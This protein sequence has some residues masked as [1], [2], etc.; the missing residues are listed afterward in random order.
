MPL[1]TKRHIQKGNE[2]TGD[3]SIATVVFLR[4]SGVHLLMNNLD[5][6]LDPAGGEV[7]L[8]LRL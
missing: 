6:N 1:A 4:N 2:C 8:L 7:V 5:F 3:L